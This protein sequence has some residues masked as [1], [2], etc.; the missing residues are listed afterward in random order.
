MYLSILSNYFFIYSQHFIV[1]DNDCTIEI[2]R[3]YPL[4][5]LVYVI[6]KQ[7]VFGDGSHFYLQK[8]SY[9]LF[10]NGTNFKKANFHA[11]GLLRGTNS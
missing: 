4:N 9:S 6:T 7:T 10:F 8:N 2:F 3:T 11:E 5:I 1:K